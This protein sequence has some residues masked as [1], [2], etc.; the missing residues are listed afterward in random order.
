[1]NELNKLVEEGKK[2]EDVLKKLD[3]KKAAVS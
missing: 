1:M 3:S 2:I